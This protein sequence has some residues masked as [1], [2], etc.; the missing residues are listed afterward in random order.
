MNKIVLIVPY[1]GKFPNY[2]QLFLNSCK[3]NRDICDWIIYTDDHSKYVIPDNV[4]FKYC[5]FSDIQKMIKNTILTEASISTPYKLCDYKPAYGMIFEDEIKQY[6]FWGHCDVDVIFGKLSHF[7]NNDVLKNDKIF[8][9]GHLCFYKNNA[10]NNRRFMYPVNDIYRYKEVMCEEDNCIFDE[11]NENG[12]I[13]I[14]EIWNQYKFSI[15][16]N[17][18]GIANT[19]YKSNRIQLIFQREGATYEREQQQHA[20]F[21]WDK[22]ELL[23]LKVE[24]KKLVMQEYMYIHLMRRTMKVKCENECE[25]Y[26]II[27]NSFEEVRAIPKDITTFNKE[28]WYTLNIQYLK[29]R[30]SNLMMKIKKKKRKKKYE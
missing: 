15:Y 16:K 5:E 12:D 8:R 18:D 29:V 9:L 3:E 25:M 4:A 11:A 14:E 1:F 6:D 10:E 17:D 21:Y 22:G 20:I 30:Y 2:F 28:K 23:R 19:Y 27:A 26:K 7:I 24:N 13:S